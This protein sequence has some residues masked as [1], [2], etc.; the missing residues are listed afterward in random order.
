MVIVWLARLSIGKGLTHQTGLVRLTRCVLYVEYM[1]ASIVT[2]LC[3]A[4]LYLLI[5]PYTTAC[6][7]VWAQNVIKIWH[8]VNDCLTSSVLCHCRM[9]GVA[10]R[11]LRP[12]RQSRK[13]EKKSK[14]KQKQLVEGKQGCG[15]VFLHL[16][17]WFLRITSI[18]IADL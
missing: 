5:L 17:K 13:E 16:I 3:Y 4:I 6:V 11:T 2:M 9:R 7:R 8:K 1:R 18:I 15:W 10:W 14:E 12:W